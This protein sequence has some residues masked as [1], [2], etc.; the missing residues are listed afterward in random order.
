MKK[1][2]L[3]RPV[4]LIA[5]LLVVA[6]GCS[7]TTRSNPEEQERQRAQTK[8][9]GDAGKSENFGD[10]RAQKESTGVSPS[11]SPTGRSKDAKAGQSAPVTPQVPAEPATP[12]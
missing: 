11:E 6:T 8:T 7:R 9:Q 10:T 5:A 2:H 1:K 4:V 3:V 12:K